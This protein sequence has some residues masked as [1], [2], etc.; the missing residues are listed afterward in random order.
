MAEKIRKTGV[1]R[2]DGYLYF[3]DKAGDISRVKMALDGQ[4]GGIPEK[5][6]KVGVLKEQGYLYF[7]DKAGDIARARLIRRGYVKRISDNSSRVTNLLR[8]T[9]E[10]IQWSEIRKRFV[11]MSYSHKDK[12]IVA[13]INK[14][15]QGKGI[16]TWFDKDQLRGGQV[17]AQEIKKAIDACVLFVT[18]L[19][20]NSVNSKGYFQ[21]EAKTAQEV[22]EKIPEGKPFIVPVIIEDN[23][24]IP[25]SIGNIQVIK[26]VS[27]RKLER[28]LYEDLKYH[29][30]QGIE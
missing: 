29:L 5:V 11:F 24:I 8:N 10:R 17:W 13:K 15:L 20:S 4:K 6:M 12:I 22:W 27:L 2:E 14:Y 26:E 3:I 1:R 7:I 9:V 19:S 28:S 18:F 16:N 25:T 21:S 23:V 30:E